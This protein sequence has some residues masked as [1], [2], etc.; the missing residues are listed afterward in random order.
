LVGI[1][2]LAL[3]DDNNLDRL[4]NQFTP[5]PEEYWYKGKKYK[6]IGDAR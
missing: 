3:L 5:A 2:V 6:W 4:K 1:T